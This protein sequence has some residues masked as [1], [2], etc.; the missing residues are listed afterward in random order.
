YDADFTQSVIGRYL[1][2]R[3]H[4]RLTLHF[5]AGS[6]VL[7]LGC[8]TGED[9][10]RLAERGVRVLATDASEGML[11]RA[12]EK[13]A[14]N[15][16]VRVKQLDLRTVTDPRLD[17]EN[18][19]WQ[20]DGA[21]SNFGPLN[22]LESYLPLAR[23]LAP[24]IKPGGIV[25]FGMMSPCCLWEPLWHGL[26]G[27]LNTATRRWRKSTP[28]QVAGSAEAITIRYPSI[29]RL[30]REF[31]PRF[32][33]RTVYPLGLFLPPSD[34]YGVIEKR[35][36]LLRTLLRLEQRFGQWGALAAF[37]DHYWIEFE[38]VD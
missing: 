15:P 11:Q 16:L 26:H 10:L 2:D 13:T 21:F 7:E 8:G 37:A 22:C 32:I 5:P 30:A 25:A 9:A 27:D 6:H 36:A 3:V 24:L 31:Y 29:R 23:W 18:I 28:F 33:R 14:G 1:R 19:E 20:F 38:R 12:R 35:P 4:E 34:V 17:A